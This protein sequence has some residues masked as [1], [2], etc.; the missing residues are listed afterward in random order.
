MK[1]QK[2]K[3]VELKAEKLELLRNCY[4]DTIKKALGL[5][6]EPTEA[7]TLEFYTIISISQHD[8][9]TSVKDRDIFYIVGLI[10][11]IEKAMEV[12]S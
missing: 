9:K 7:D 6:N 11:G 1:Q 3:L 10:D 5:D 4:K 2:E 12:L 8:G